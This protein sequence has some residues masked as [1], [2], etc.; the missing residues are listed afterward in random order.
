M[1][2]GIVSVVF[3]II[4]SALFF[5]Q[6]QTT[7]AAP[8]IKC[9]PWEPT[10]CGCHQKKDPQTNQC[11]Q[12]ANTYGCPCLDVTNGYPTPG[13]CITPETIGPNPH[14]KGS[15]KKAEGEG[16]PPQMPQLPQ[17]PKSEPKP[18][19]KPPEQQP[20]PKKPNDIPFDQYRPVDNLASTPGTE[21][22]SV[23]DQLRT[24]TENPSESGTLNA[25]DPFPGLNSGAN[26]LALSELFA[27][28]SPLQSNTGSEN[29]PVA[30]ETN[31]EFSASGPQTGFLSDQNS[32]LSSQPEPQ[33][34]FANA[35]NTATREIGTVVNDVVSAAG[36]WVSDALGLSSQQ[37][38]G[39]TYDERAGWEG[40][41]APD[42][43]FL[44]QA[45]LAAPLL[46]GV[47]IPGGSLAVHND[48][49]E[50][51]GASEFQP[52]PRYPMQEF[53]FPP[54]EYNIN[55]EFSAP[56]PSEYVPLPGTAW[57]VS[58]EGNLVQNTLSEPDFSREAGS[59]SMSFS[60]SYEES[61]IDVPEPSFVD[62]FQSFVVDPV[63][64]WISNGWTYL[65]SFF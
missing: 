21:N 63:V 6:Y 10:D 48:Q 28:T 12:D 14:C 33:N 34:A 54:S 32:E 60:Y 24:L 7:Y 49:G 2:F 19:Q 13:T 55:N 29:G 45:D 5:L 3:S 41:G 16:K 25:E 22:T 65:T 11:K 42:P 9:D 26:S 52:E 59:I 8:V 53:P 17:P 4:I 47:P 18:E 50:V 20:E 43:Y 30:Q 57:Y 51:V 23:E 27:E 1:K 61:T 64:N 58:P 39:P 40:E 38:S 35:V 46:E 31:S 56:I 37:F 15:G 36:N 62:S 44:P